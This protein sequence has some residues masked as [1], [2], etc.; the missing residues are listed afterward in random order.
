MIH[1]HFV[2]KKFFLSQK[3]ER[4]RGKLNGE[5]REQCETLYFQRREKNFPA[6]KLRR[7]F[8]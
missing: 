3:R 5:R 7:Q 2:L 8:F 1:R 4:R 6:L